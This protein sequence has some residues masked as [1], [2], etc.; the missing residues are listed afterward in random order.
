MP[1][2]GAVRTVDEPVPHAEVQKLALPHLNALWSPLFSANPTPLSTQVL[3]Q[4]D[5]VRPSGRP[6]LGLNDRPFRCLRPR[7]Q[8]GDASV[9]RLSNWNDEQHLG[10]VRPDSAPSLSLHC[11]QAGYRGLGQHRRFNQTKVTPI[12]LVDQLIGGHPNGLLRVLRALPIAEERM[13][14]QHEQKRL[15]IG[16]LQNRS[17]QDC[18]VETCSQPSFND[19]LSSTD[20]LARIA[21]VHR[22]IRVGNLVGVDSRADGPDDLR[23]SLWASLVP[24]ERT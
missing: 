23:D 6:I 8:C 17:E 9:T 12:N 10:T 21:P 18:G 2:N 3:R 15:Y 1:V 7:G 11:R 16:I 22:K 13:S 20:S 24:L 19:F 5:S 4:D 14:S